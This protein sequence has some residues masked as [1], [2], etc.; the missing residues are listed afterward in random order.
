[1]NKTS[2]ALI[3][4][5]LGTILLASSACNRAPNFV[6]EAAGHAISAW[7]KGPYSVAT[8]DAH[9]VISGPFG[10]V[11]IGRAQVKVND[12]SWNSIPEGAPVRLEMDRSRVRIKADKVTISHG[13][14]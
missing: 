6:T 11:V 13:V 3:T 14:R 5:T 7:I 4:L 9:A 2:L 1:M 8:E 10:K 12:G